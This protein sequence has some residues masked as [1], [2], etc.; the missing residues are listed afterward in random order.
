MVALRSTAGSWWRAGTIR[1]GLWG[2]A[3]PRPAPEAGHARGVLRAC[4]RGV[5]GQLLT[6]VAVAV[7]GAT[8]GAG[9]RAV[10]RRPRI[11]RDEARRFAGGVASARERS[12]DIS[13]GRAGDRA[14]AQG[15]AGGRRN[16]QRPP[17][18]AVAAGGRHERRR[19]RR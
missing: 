10:G 1:I 17:V 19:L 16:G 3:A 6:L 8:G 11:A 4:I 15:L 7:W 2:W 18:L 14:G 12:E 5:D 13:H 9:T